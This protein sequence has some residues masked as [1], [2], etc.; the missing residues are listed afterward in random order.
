MTKSNPDSKKRSPARRQ[1]N[2]K[3]FWWFLVLLLLVVVTMV[4]AFYLI[5]LFGPW[6]R[7]RQE[8]RKSLPAQQV[9]PKKVPPKSVMQLTPPVSPLPSRE[10]EAKPL[11]GTAPPPVQ[12]ETQPGAKPRVAIV[13]DDMGYHRDTGERLIKLNLPLS[14]AFLPHGPFTADLQNEAKRQGRDI[15]LHFP[16]EPDNAKV[17]AGPGVVTLGMVRGGLDKIFAEDLAQVP[18]AIGVNN[19]MGSKFTRNREA[20]QAFLHQLKKRD[21]FFLDSRTD[22]KSV[23]EEMAKDLGIKTGHRSV[24]LDNDQVREKVE[25]QLESLY[26]AAEKHGSAIGIGHPSAATLAV[27][28]ELARNP[29]QRVTVVAVHEL[30][31]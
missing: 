9:M 4:A 18:K 6:E 23:G 10:E 7:G 3:T 17:D 19:H 22:V 12:P 27:L 26:A 2:R 30:I 21:L 16:M 25:A 11:L 24:F 29:G 5:F 31:R 1:K 8:V 14:F 13:I 28:A 20:M 15:L